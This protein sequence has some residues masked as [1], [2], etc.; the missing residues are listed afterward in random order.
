MLYFASLIVFCWIVGVW[1]LRG[2]GKGR[3]DELRETQAEMD[4][5]GD[6]DDKRDAARRI[7]EIIDRDELAGIVV[8]DAKHAAEAILGRS[9]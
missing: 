6:I 5:A 2:S 1:L 9:F 4:A 8:D 7:L 3:L